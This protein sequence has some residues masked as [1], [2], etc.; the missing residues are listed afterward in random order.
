MNCACWGLTLRRAETPTNPHDPSIPGAPATR[1]Q[2]QQRQALAAAAALPLA[3]HKARGG[4]GAAAQKNG[5]G[6]L[7]QAYLDELDVRWFWGDFEGFER[8]MGSS[9]AG[10]R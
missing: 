9:S 3:L 7:L 6:S 1:R 5:G 4:A 10:G 8:E 2:Q